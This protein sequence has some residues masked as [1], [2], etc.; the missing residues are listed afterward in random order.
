MDLLPEVMD[1]TEDYLMRF[2]NQIPSARSHT[3]L[4]VSERGDAIALQSINKVFTVLRSKFPELPRSLTPHIWRHTW[5]TLLSEHL[6]SRNASPEDERRVRTLL[7][8]WS[9]LSTA[10]ETYL[11]RYIKEMARGISL[12]MQRSIF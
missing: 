2:R 9:P 11:Q 12:Q 7:M 10:P 5:N 6:K 4:F 1:R 3:F 8:G